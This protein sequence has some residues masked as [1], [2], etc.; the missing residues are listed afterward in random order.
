MPQAHEKRISQSIFNYRNN[1]YYNIILYK[2][3]ILILKIIFDLNVFIIDGNV[4]SVLVYQ[5]E[6]MMNPRLTIPV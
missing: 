2:C 1:I 3:Q 4:Q 6:Q 5:N